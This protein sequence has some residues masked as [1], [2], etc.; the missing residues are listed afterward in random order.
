MIPWGGKS[1]LI[2]IHVVNMEVDMLHLKLLGAGEARY[3]DRALDGFPYQQPFLLLCYLLINKVKPHHRESL[4]AVF[5]GDYPTFTARKYL[6]NTLYR[7]RSRFDSVG[8]EIGKLLSITEETVS[9]VDTCPY[10]LDVECFET[11]TSHYQS[12]QVANLLPEQADELVKGVELYKG[13]L[14][15]GV[16][17]DWCLYD[18]ERLRLT[19]LEALH[20]LML[21]S[22]IHN[23][24]EQGLQYGERILKLDPTR[25]KVHRQ[26]MVLHWLAGDGPAALAQYKRCFQILHEEMDSQPMAETQLLY[27]KMAHNQFEP[28]LTPDGHIFSPASETTKGYPAKDLELILRCL[29]HLQESATQISNDVQ[30]VQKQI[31]LMLST[32]YLERRQGDNS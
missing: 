11:I 5:W 12:Y 7:L 2:I 28:H 26:M 1:A 19:Y 17:D 22:T 9:F 13:D 15:E 30:Q 20:K 14:L 31:R 4:A 10:W 27:E 6:R 29:D 23:D 8:L 21:Y 24:Y 18:R 3:F 16:Y 25:E 32:K